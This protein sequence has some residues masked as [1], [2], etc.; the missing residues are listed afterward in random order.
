MLNINRIKIIINKFP[1]KIGVACILLF[2]TSLAL[3]Q[4]STARKWNE[5]LLDAIRVDYARPTVHARNLFHSAIVMYDAW[6]VYD[7]TAQTFF[8]GNSLSGYYCPFDGIPTPS[9]V[10]EARSEAISYAV[11]RVLKHRF[12]NSPGAEESLASFD[13]LMT[14]LGYET[15][16]VSTDYSDGSPAKLGNYLAEQIIEFGL[17]DGA[18]ESLGY[19]N[20]YYAPLNDPMDPSKA[21]GQG[22]NDPNHWQPL[23]FDFFIDQAGFEIPGG[24][25]HFLGPEWGRV[26]PFALTT[27]ELNIYQRGRVLG[28]P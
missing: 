7:K 12:Q 11:Y 10:A 28:I 18:N 24:I 1:I 20:T 2:S 22:I 5:V 15:E 14:N 9:S 17:Q 21:G 19:R 25:P 4:E 13:D 23:A 3:A 27:D 26:V 16:V 8:L 6:A